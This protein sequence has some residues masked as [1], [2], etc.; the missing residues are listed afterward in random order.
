MRRIA[1]ALAAC[2][3]LACAGSRGEKRPLSVSDSDYGRLQA[4][5]TQPVD[6]ARAELSRARDELARAKLRQTEAQSEDQLAKSDLQAVD[7]AQTRANALAK[8]AS[9]SREPAK[10]EEA[11]KAKEHADLRKRTAEA[12]MEYARKLQANRT[13]GVKAAEQRVAFESSRVEAAKLQALQQ[14]QIPAAGK[15]DGPRIEAQ[16]AQASK[17]LEKAEGEVRKS[18]AEVTAAKQRWEELNRQLQAQAG[19]R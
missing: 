5:Q 2:A 8:D 6:A 10:L 14:A 9:A 4:G 18:E 15:Y 7:A 3:V 13:A 16:V 19:G 12:H 1:T 11:R 17:E